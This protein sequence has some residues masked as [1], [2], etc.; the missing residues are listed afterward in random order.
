MQEA[1]LR[2]VVAV[3]DQ[4]ARRVIARVQSHAVRGIEFLEAVPLD[5]EVLQVF[6]RLVELEDVVAPVTVCQKDVSVG[7]NGN[8]RGIELLRFQSRFLGKSELQ[9]DLSGFGV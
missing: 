5:S 6:P 9:H 4:E 3:A 8:R 7:S 1:P 2:L